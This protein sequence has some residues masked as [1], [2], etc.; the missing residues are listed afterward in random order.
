M[1]LL[2]LN[3]SGGVLNSDLL[4]NE[5]IGHQSG[6]IIQCIRF[7]S[8]RELG[9]TISSPDNWAPYFREVLKWIAKNPPYGGIYLGCGNPI[10]EG[11]MML[12]VYDSV[13]YP[14]ITELP[15]YSSGM[16]YTYTGKGYQFGTGE[17]KFWCKQIFNPQISVN[18][19][20]LQ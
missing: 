1:A 17:G 8:F 2:K 14:T 9:L 5:S 4:N 10:S 15:R 18:G 13:I 19:D 7:P 6:N 3:D 11:V 20:P 16:Y 12:Y